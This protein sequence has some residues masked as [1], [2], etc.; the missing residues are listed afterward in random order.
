[1]RK[2][3]NMQ[4]V[5]QTLIARGIYEI[6]LCGDLVRT[7]RVPGQFVHVKTSD[8][9]SNDSLLRRPIS[10]CELDYEKKQLTLLYRAQGAGTD[11]LARR[12]AGDVVDV[13]GPLGSGFPPETVTAG[14]RAILIGGGI[15]VPP[16]YELARQLQ[17][18]GKPV[19]A[20]L[21]F[22]TQ[23]DVF[24]EGKFRA[25]CDEV[26]ITTMDG[27]YGTKGTVLDV[28]QAEN[29]DFDCLF[30]CGPDVMLHALNTAYAGAKQGYLSFEARM[31]CGMGACYACVCALN[32]GISARICKEG[33]VFKM[34]EVAL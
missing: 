30:A 7:M 22:G 28:I 18:Q 32:S 5:R 34:G 25:V 11:W 21:G 19:I 9:G 15:G 1:M 2:T 27:S 31:A 12:Q 16:L 14:E 8:A 23:A 4:I 29:L 33:P 26:Y 6:V 17:G 3:Q 24:Y 20:V 10:I 13:M